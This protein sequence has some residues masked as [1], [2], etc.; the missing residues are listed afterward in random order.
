[1]NIGIR[2]L[3][4]DISGILSSL[5]KDKI[6]FI[7]KTNKPVGA[8]LHIDKL[9]DL[10]TKANDA[11]VLQLI[12]K[13]REEQGVRFNKVRSIWIKAVK[14]FLQ[15]SKDKDVPSALSEK[16]ENVVFFLE[17]VI[18]ER[19]TPQ[20]IRLLSAITNKFE[21][22]V[23]PIVDLDYFRVTESFAKGVKKSI[24]EFVNSASEIRDEEFIGDRNKMIEFADHMVIIS[25]KEHEQSGTTF[26]KIILSV[27]TKKD[28]RTYK[29]YSLIPFL[30]RGGR[31]SDR[32]IQQEDFQKLIIKNH[33]PGQ[34]FEYKKTQYGV[35]AA[36]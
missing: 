3:R 14:D 15:R 20:N 24:G 17:N 9:S 19:E 30:Y 25:D 12:D 7:T 22:I 35:E 32:F 18:S 27:K 36:M 8:L 34:H 5:D 6:F 23:V 29:V 28:N 1:M 4:K 33:K 21:E 2:D 13:A 16:L 11:S 10:A 31:Y 26:P